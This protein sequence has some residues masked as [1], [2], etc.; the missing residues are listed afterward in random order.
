MEVR[1]MT[2]FNTRVLVVDD[3]QQVCTL[4]A[5]LLRKEGFK[6]IAAYDGSVALKMIRTEMPDMMLVD[7]MM[8]GMDGMELLKKAKEMD[9]ELPVVMITG[10][11]DIPGAVKAMKAGAHDYISKPF[12][13]HEVIRVVHRALAERDLKRKIFHLSSQLQENYSL[14]EMMGPSDAIDRLISIVNRVAKSDFTVVIQGETGTGKE[15]VARAIHQAST[16]SECN[17]IPVDCGAIPSALLESELFGYE[18]GAFTDAKVQKAGK[19]EIAQGGTLFL[20]EITNMPLGSQAKLLRAL[21]E[22]NIYRV[23]GNKPLKVDVRLLTSCNTN[24]EAEV[25]SGSFRQDLFY[26]LNEFTINIPPL[27]ERCDDVLYLANRFQG[28]TNIELNKHVKGFTESAL[29]ALI[30][31]NWPG[32]VRQ[33]RSI[34]R[35]AVLL[36]DDVVTEK[37]L[38]LKKTPTPDLPTVSKVFEETWNGLSLKEIVKRQIID[39]ERA[40]LSKTL[41][42]TGD[43]KAKAARLLRIDYKTIH[44]KVKQLGISIDGETI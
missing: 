16:R 17:F 8:P 25:Q 34:I 24:I 32:N 30:T 2:E 1:A 40:V 5:K 23:G 42:V 19:F 29:D 15:L 43:N 9:P 6:T 28:I 18:R 20:D 12:K 44:T 3:E 27:W 4:L 37:H 13:N 10:Y 26:R 41:K 14:R 38:D 33:L 7:F 11:A 21:Q 35:R 36:A 31:Y 39:V 22:K